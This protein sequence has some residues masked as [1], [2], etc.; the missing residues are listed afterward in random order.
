MRYHFAI[1]D[2]HVTS[3]DVEGID[4]ADHQS[5]MA[6]ALDDA[7]EILSD[8]DRQGLCRRHWRVDVTDDTGAVLFSVP[9]AQALQADYLPFAPQALAA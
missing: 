1:N 8:S 5:A 3:P 7:R 9:F 4:L 6:E 2:G